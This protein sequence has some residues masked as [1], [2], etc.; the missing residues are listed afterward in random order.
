MS[1]LIC[2]KPILYKYWKNG[3]SSEEEWVIKNTH[4]GVIEDK[5][6]NDI[7]EFESLQENEEDMLKWKRL[8]DNSKS[9]YNTVHEFVCRKPF[10]TDHHLRCY[11]V[12]G[13]SSTQLVSIEWWLKLKLLQIKKVWLNW[14]LQLSYKI[15]PFNYYK[16]LD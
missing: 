16:H 1:K 5:L 8:Q 6:Y 4:W 2:F 13:Q 14:M 7:R 9:F 10:T 12:M 11:T 15:K 3:W